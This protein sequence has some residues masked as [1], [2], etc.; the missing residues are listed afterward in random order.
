MWI[1]S[2]PGQDG[3]LLALAGGLLQ[4][5]NGS[6]GRMGRLKLTSC[7]TVREARLD[8]EEKKDRIRGHAS[9]ANRGAALGGATDRSPVSLGKPCLGSVPPTDS[10]FALKSAGLLL[11]PVQQG[12]SMLNG[13]STS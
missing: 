8:P 13:R 11:W 3:T 6:C 2:G 1:L 7:I 4:E 12:R 5:A 9:A 10:G